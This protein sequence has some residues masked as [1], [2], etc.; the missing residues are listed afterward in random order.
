M[1]FEFA[2]DVVSTSDEKKT[3]PSIDRLQKKRF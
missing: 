2:E 1:V 3:P